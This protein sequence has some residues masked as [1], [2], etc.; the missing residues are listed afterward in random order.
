MNELDFDP[1]QFSPADGIWHIVDRNSLDDLER[2]L[3]TVVTGRAANGHEY[4]VAFTDQDLAK[5]FIERIRTS[6]PDAVPFPIHDQRAWLA[7]LEDLMGI[8]REYI[9]F[10]P[11]PG[12]R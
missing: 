6:L 2:V 7:F 1:Q 8:G 10:D 5:Q 9:A 4:V 3:Q 11:E 12:R